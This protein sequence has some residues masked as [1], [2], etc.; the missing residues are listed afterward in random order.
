MDEDIEDCDVYAA[1]SYAVAVSHGH[2][3]K[4]KINLKARVDTQAGEVTFYV[5]PDKIDTLRA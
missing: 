2:R 1:S 5:P 3:M 4:Q